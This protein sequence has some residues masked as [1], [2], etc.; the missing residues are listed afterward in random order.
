[1]NPIKPSQWW[2]EFLGQ[3]VAINSKQCQGCA[4]YRTKIRQIVSHK[5]DKPEERKD[6]SKKKKEY[7]TDLATHRYISHSFILFVIIF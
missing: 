6:K 3:S 4:E 5:K 7:I 1:M 2:D